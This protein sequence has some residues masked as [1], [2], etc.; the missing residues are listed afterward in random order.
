[1]RRPGCFSGAWR[2]WHLQVDCLH[3]KCW[4]IYYICH[5]NLLLLVSERS[6]RDRPLREA[7][8]IRIYVPVYVLSSTPFVKALAR[9]ANDERLTDR[10]PKLS[11][12]TLFPPG[13]DRIYGS[14]CHQHVV[15]ISGDPEVF[16]RF[17]TLGNSCFF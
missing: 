9:R 14:T 16:S 7:A 5:S 15:P 10:V 2:S 4:T 8:C 11:F 1:M 13:T 17:L 12:I 3:P 6:G